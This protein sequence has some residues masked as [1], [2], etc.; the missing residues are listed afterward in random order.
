LREN[1]IRTARAK[2]LREMVVVAR[3]AL[4]NAMIPVITY[5]GPILAAV[6]TGTFV[7]ETIFGIPGLGRHFIESVGNRDY[8]LVVGTALLY[9]LLLVT[10]NLFVDITYAWLDPRIRYE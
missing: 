9:A 7:V 10:A 8:P 6:L 2:G 4:K 5:L 3:H 1:Y